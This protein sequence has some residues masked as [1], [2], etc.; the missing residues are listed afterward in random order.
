MADRIVIRKEIPGTVDKLSFHFDFDKPRRESGRHEAI[1]RYAKYKGISPN[2]VKNVHL[3]HL[4]LDRSNE[5][6]A[7]LFVCDTQKQHQNLHGQLQ[8]MNS[9]MIK[10]GLVKFDWG[11]K[12]YYVAEP[13]LRE[14]F[15]EMSKPMAGVLD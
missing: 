4:D 6:P 8:A 10:N 9:L 2:K 7:N 3:H 1:K 11:G 5:H 12:Y 13:A 15:I 14:K